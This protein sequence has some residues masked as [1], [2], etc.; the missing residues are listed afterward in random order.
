[1]NIVQLPPK[2]QTSGYD[3][4]SYFRSAFIEVRKKTVEKA[5]SISCVAVYL[6]HQLVGFL[7]LRILSVM[8]CQC[9][10]HS[11]VYHLHCYI[12]IYEVGG[13][14]STAVAES[15]LSTPTGAVIQTVLLN[16]AITVAHNLNPVFDNIPHRRLSSC[17]SPRPPEG[18]QMPGATSAAS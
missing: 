6:P 4:I 10:L 14:R 3:V 1:M 11:S 8:S 16:L 15:L 17:F 5:A 18:H 2:P 12:V 13:R 9:H 7:L